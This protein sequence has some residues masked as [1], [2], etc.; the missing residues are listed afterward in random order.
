[1]KPLPSPL[2]KS[3][4]FSLKN[5]KW[6]WKGSRREVRGEGAGQFWEAE[7][8]QRPPGRYFTC[9]KHQVQVGNEVIGQRNRRQPIRRRG[10]L[11]NIG[12]P[13]QDPADSWIIIGTGSGRLQFPRIFVLFVIRLVFS[14]LLFSCFSSAN[15]QEGG[16]VG[17]VWRRAGGRGFDSRSRTR[18]SFIKDGTERNRCDTRL[19]SGQLLAVLLTHVPPLWLPDSKC[20]LLVFFRRWIAGF[21]KYEIRW[22]ELIIILWIKFI[23]SLSVFLKIVDSSFVI[24]LISKLSD[25]NVSLCRAS[26]DGISVIFHFLVPWVEGS[27]RRVSSETFRR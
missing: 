18:L 22:G 27:G 10:P 17:G 6:K 26:N 25:F 7:A 9:K 24:Y 1:M 12:A 8:P 2:N 16:P 15:G 21:W 23:S 4:G 11:D 20:D 13:V 19:S 5:V 3:I 14:A